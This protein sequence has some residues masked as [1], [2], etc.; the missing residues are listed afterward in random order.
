LLDQ[1]SIV[2]RR[3]HF[4]R[5]TEQAYRY[6]IRQ[7]IL[8]H[9]KRHPTELEPAQVEAFLN[10][11]AVARRVAASTQSQ[12]LNAIVFLYDAVLGKPLGQMTGL[13]RVQRRQRIPVVLNRDEVS[14]VLA[15]MHGACRLMAE[16]MYGAGL[17]VHECVTLRVKDVDFTARTISIRNSKGSK[18]RTT[19]LPEQL[20]PP[21]QQH[22]LRVAVLHRADLMRGASI[23]EPGECYGT[24]ANRTVRGQP[25]HW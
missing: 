13:Q 18:D 3:R 7:F 5:N 22:L 21:L 1:V 2:C 8:F 6:W 10:H 14:R 4:S 25:W 15:L 19:V 20:C 23:C 9:G 12:A 11:L 17:R 24:V 16:L